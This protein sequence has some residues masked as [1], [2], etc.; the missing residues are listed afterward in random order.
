[1]MDGLVWTWCAIPVCYGW[2]LDSS[3]EFAY[4]VYLYCSNTIRSLANWVSVDSY[5]QLK[6]KNTTVARSPYTN[7]RIY[8]LTSK[9][10]IRS[11]GCRTRTRFRLHSWEIERF[12]PSNLS[13]RPGPCSRSFTPQQR[14]NP[15]LYI[16]AYCERD[17]LALRDLA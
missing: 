4:F 8:A 11:L 12:T 5:Y 9:S 15:G 13:I 14:S 10:D 16:P 6:Y 2:V 7:A 1:M 3:L 17:V